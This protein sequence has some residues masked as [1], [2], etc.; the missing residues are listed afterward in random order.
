MGSNSTHQRHG[1]GAQTE[2]KI[3]FNR[4]KLNKLFDFLFVYWYLCI[5]FSNN[6]DAPAEKTAVKSTWG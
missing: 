6:G 1:T 2:N 4:V 5:S 3:N